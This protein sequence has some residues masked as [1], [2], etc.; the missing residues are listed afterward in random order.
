MQT[1]LLENQ[2]DVLALSDT[3]K[4][5]IKRQYFRSLEHSSL[6]RVITKHPLLSPKYQTTTMK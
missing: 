1:K 2:T 5:E 4:K 6:A 3:S